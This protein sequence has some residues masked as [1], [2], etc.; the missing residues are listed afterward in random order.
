MRF[1]IITQIFLK[2]MFQSNIIRKKNFFYNK[3]IKKSKKIIKMDLSS[4]KLYVYIH[5]K[6][7]TYCKSKII[8][9]HHKKFEINNNKHIYLKRKTTYSSQFVKNQKCIIEL[10]KILKQ[11]RIQNLII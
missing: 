5:E 7:K 2:Y 11:R 9:F 3:R 4:E 10:S 8:L 6:E 1:F